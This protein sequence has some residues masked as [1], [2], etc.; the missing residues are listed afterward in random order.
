MTWQHVVALAALTLILNGCDE[1][2]T[3]PTRTDLTGRW[4]LSSLQPA[5]SPPLAPRPGTVVGIEFM[6]DRIS[7]QSDCNTCSGRYTM[8]G[9]SLVFSP[10]ACTRRACLEGSI[11]GP[12][13]QLLSTA[14]S[15]TTV[16]GRIL[17]IEGPNGSLLFTR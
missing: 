7:V 9:T 13:L 6:D 17:R 16:P 12:F 8:S 4:Q 3:A 15:A 14:S 1:A 5:H 10:M 2:L 11:E